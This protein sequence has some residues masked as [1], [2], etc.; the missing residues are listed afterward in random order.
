MIDVIDKSFPF[1]LREEHLLY[2]QILSN[3]DPQ[4]LATHCLRNDAASAASH[5]VVIVRK[6][7]Y[8]V[9]RDVL[10]SLLAARDAASGSSA[11]A[12]SA[13]SIPTSPGPP[14]PP[15]PPPSM[16]VEEAEGGVESILSVVFKTDE[17]LLHIEMFEWLF[18]KNMQVC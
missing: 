11:A 4:N 10:S 12:A 13:P 15:P 5:P 18:A 3:Q 14:S 1:F 6:K 8:D 2:F 9:V 7:C 16:S 17:E